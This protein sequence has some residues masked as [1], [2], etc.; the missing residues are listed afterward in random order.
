ML[1]GAADGEGVEVVGQDAPR[2][3]GAGTLMSSQAAALEAVFALEVAD[4]AFGADAVARQSPVRALG[5]G[6]AAPGDEHAAASGQ[7]VVDGT[8]REAAV[9]R[10][11]ARRDF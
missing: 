2:D 6:A 9:E 10:D 1:S 4:A 3:P 8:G 11:V 7:V 5:A